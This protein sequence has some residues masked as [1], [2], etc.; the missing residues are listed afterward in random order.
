M[1]R[2]LT[3]LATV[4][5]LCT[6]LCVSASASDF[7]DVATELSAI[8]MFRG[9]G[10]SFELDRAPTRAEAAIMLTRLYGAEEAA[11]GD[12]A[13]GK[14]AH[15]FTDV[16]DFAAPHIAWLY[17]EGLTKGMSAD[18]F[19]SAAACSAQSYAT[20]LLRALGYQDGEDFEYADALAFAQEKGFYSPLMF[21]GE[22]L[23]D[24]LAALTYQALAA[25][26]KDGKTYLLAQLIKDGA[27]DRDAAAPMTE[28]MELYRELGASDGVVKNDCLDVDVLMSLDMTMTAEGETITSQ[29]YASGNV[30]AIVD[31]TDV[32]MAYVLST[33]SD[34]TMMD[35]G[36][37]MKDGWVYQYV[38]D[39]A[40]TQTI[41]YAVE[42]E[43][44]MLEELGVAEVT[45]VDVSALAAVKSITRETDGTDTVYTMVIAEGMGGIMENVMN[46]AAGQ[47]LEGIGSDMTANIGEVS[48]YYMLDRKGSLKELGMQMPYYMMM[49][50]A[51]EDGTVI[52][53]E[54]SCDMRMVMTV[55]ATGD[56]VKIEYPDLSAFVEVV[57][58]EGTTLPAA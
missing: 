52:P 8:G 3:M 50:I 21:G 19:G 10:T 28:K 42:D 41:K 40:L 5:M 18:Q 7:D 39:G 44:A 51:D 27:V 25:D 15:P 2:F 49:N 30:Q 26:T 22:F 46:F 55:N 13:E 16:P 37:W 38:S 20:F 56:D 23:R 32:E 33:I 14:I 31:G 47:S 36:V 9:T 24:D 58:T 45:G 12:Y 34:G 11:A 6:A 53:V 57:P 1:K 35:M 29:T 17:T 4:L 43:L 48:I 54:A